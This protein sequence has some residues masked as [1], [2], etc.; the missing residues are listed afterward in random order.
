VYYATLILLWVGGSLV[1]RRTA[2]WHFSYLSNFLLPLHGVENMEY[3]AHFWSLAVEEQFYLLWPWVI[4]FLPARYLERTLL[5]A[6][7]VAPAYRGLAGVIGPTWLKGAP[8][9]YFDTLGVGALLAY[10]HWNAGISGR[11]WNRRVLE[12]LALGSVTA[13]TVSVS[14]RTGG[15]AT[16]AFLDQ[17]LMAPFMGWLVVG[18]AAGFSGLPG[19][20]LENRTAQYLGKISYGLYIFHMF[21]PAVLLR[22]Y[23]MFDL[24]IIVRQAFYLRLP[25]YL[26]LTVLVA[27]LSWHWFERPINNLKKHFPY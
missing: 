27:S 11:P 10:W 22:L 16:P 3:L 14:L 23:Y 25:I 21:M 18:A 13:L 8:I 26:G 4:V 9:T 1:M 20:L 15:V 12:W 5:L 7:V 17:T 2:P 6:I 24:P 19:R